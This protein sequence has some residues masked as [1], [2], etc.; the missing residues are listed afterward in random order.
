MKALDCI[1]IV[2]E[3]YGKEIYAKLPEQALAY[4]LM[5]D[6]HRRFINGLICYYQPKRVLEIGVCHGGGSSV[7]LNAI[8][9]IPNSKLYSID[10]AKQ[11]NKLVNGYP[12]GELCDTGYVAKE[13]Y[14]DTLETEKWVLITGNDPVDVIEGLNERFDFCVIDTA[15]A[16]PVETLN[17]LTVLPFLS[18]GAIVVLDDLV[19]YDLFCAPFYATRLLYSSV[20]GPKRK[21]QD[22]SLD[23]NNVAAFQVTSDTNKYIENV[24]HSLLFPWHLMT[25]NIEAIGEFIKRHYDEKYHRQFLVAAKFARMRFLKN[26]ANIRYK[27][28]DDASESF[29]ARSTKLAQYAFSESARNYFK[30][31][32]CSGR[33]I[34]Y[35]GGALANELI[36]LLIENEMQEFLPTEIWDVRAEEIKELYGIPVVKPSFTELEHSDYILVCVKILEAAKSVFNQLDQIGFHNYKHLSKLEELF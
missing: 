35:G 25:S 36:Q 9:E 21:I 30:T 20:V 7:L 26:K 22:D 17:F 16:H 27:W 31:S 6:S 13:I 24:F 12:S 29:Y 5:Y 23:D 1:E 18:D 33:L 4:S 11:I 15:H 10:I 2:P 14:G 3:Q 19:M 32:P 28:A 34:Y 8:K